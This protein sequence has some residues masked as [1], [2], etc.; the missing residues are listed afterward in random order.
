MYVC[1]TSTNVIF[2]SHS[3]LHSVQVDSQTNFKTLTLTLAH[4]LTHT[5]CLMSS[6]KCWTIFHKMTHLHNSLLIEERNGLIRIGQDHIYS[7]RCISYSDWH[8]LQND[9]FCQL[10][11]ISRQHTVIFR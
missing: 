3:L 8:K 7:L 4:A 9:M 10:P 11:L 5:I 2:R 6:P 1:S